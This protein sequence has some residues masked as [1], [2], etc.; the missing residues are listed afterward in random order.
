[1]SSVLIVGA[2]AVGAFYGSALARAGAQVS[3]VCRSDFAEV[4]ERGFDIASALLGDHVFRP[5]AVLRDVSEHRGSPDYLILTSKVVQGV[6]RAALIR[7]AVGPSTT[8]VLIQNGIDIESPIA[9]AFAQNE[10]LSAL[11]FIGVGRTAPGRVHHQSLGWLMLGRYP[12]GVTTGAEHLA[13]LF[14]TAGVKCRLTDDVITARWQ[15]AVWNAVFNPISVLGGGLDTQ[16]ILGGDGEQLVRTAMQE[17][18]DVAAATGHALPPSL[19][20]QLL[21]ATRG[22]G[23]YKT[24]MALDYENARPMETEAIVGNVVRAARQHRVAAPTLE[25][26]YA[27]VKRVE[28]NYRA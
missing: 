13:R 11:A 17:V 19:I 21:T 26:L 6:D 28:D 22:M 12:S 16:T 25:T 23:A 8:L 15:K 2:G 4:S 24:S 10:L 27:L 9:S 1:M 7:P 14:E 5:H 3:V 18:C 20:D